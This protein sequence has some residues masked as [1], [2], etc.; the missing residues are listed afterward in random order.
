M[1]AT[2]TADRSVQ[3]D[4]HVTT[5]RCCSSATMEDLLVEVDCGANTGPDRYVKEVARLG[6]GAPDR[7]RQPSSI[8]IVLHSRR[9]AI[10][11][12]YPFPK[13]KIPPASQVWRF[14]NY[15]LIWIER[16]RCGNNNGS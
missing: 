12:F 3:L 15:A 6:A 10:L 8:R 14:E 16:S 7:L 4:S 2:T 11:L 5:L 9:Q 1:L 13:R